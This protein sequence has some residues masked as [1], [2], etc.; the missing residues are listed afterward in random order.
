MDTKPTISA[1]VITYNEE[2][3][4]VNCLETL[5]WCD[6]IVVVDSGSKDMTV[7]LAE[8]A[9]A[10]IV[11]EKSS[12]FA[13]RRNTGLKFAQS[14]WVLYIDADERVTPRLAKEIQAA[15][16]QQHVSV[17]KVKRNNIHY[18]K[19]LEHGGWEKDLIER[20][21]RKKD[22]KRWT[23]Q[24][25]ESPDY[26]GNVAQLAEPLVHLT[27]RNMVDGLRKTI[28]WTGYEAQLLFEAG[29]K[30]VTPRTLIRK[31]VMEFIRRAF[32]KKGRKDGIE[33]W[34][35][36]MTQAMNKFIVYERLWELQKKPSLEDTYLKIDETIIKQ[37]NKK[38]NNV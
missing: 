9:G 4:I 12:S 29:H 6:E 11:K 20:L 36:A 15:V 2:L 10:K 28:E 22:L 38:N 13:D 7:G 17:Y 27:H 35:E 30:P 24:V 8:R 21:F 16:F 25:H 19:W 5:K 37:W 26:T 3:M 14:D 34:I 23:G 18:G 31:T 1:V 32:L 33:G